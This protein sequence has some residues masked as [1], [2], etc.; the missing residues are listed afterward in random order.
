MQTNK[1]PNN[2]PTL[3]HPTT[4]S[5][6]GVIC[7]SCLVLHIKQL[8]KN[9]MGN[10]SRNVSLFLHQHS[11][12]GFMLWGSRWHFSHESCDDGLSSGSTK[13]IWLCCKFGHSTGWGLLWIFTFFIFFF[14][15][16]DNLA[17]AEKCRNIYRIK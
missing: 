15:I 11:E 13:L 9:K 4:R 8:T 2:D 12:C 10:S 6:A 17:I 3:I 16:S 5:W 7:G 14:L 1:R